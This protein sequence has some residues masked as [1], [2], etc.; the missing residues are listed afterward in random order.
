MRSWPH[1]PPHWTH[2][3]GIYF[4]TASTHRK[5][6]HFDNPGRLDLLT[7]LILE[8][9]E[10]SGWQPDAWAVFANHYHLIL[11]S[12]VSSRPL[13]RVIGKIHMQS[14]KAINEA[15]ESSGRKIWHNYRDTHLTFEKSH[16]AR[17]HYVIHNPVRHGLV[18]NAELY[19]WCSA[20][21]FARHASPAFVKTVLSFPI[22]RL[23]IEDDF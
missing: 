21:W 23:E 2:E 16:L 15:D 9:L 12:T 8:V 1:A 5:Q 3:P 10:E 20:A 6:R 13:S 18:P 17:L 7:G 4:V 19:P 11:R 22:D 14:A